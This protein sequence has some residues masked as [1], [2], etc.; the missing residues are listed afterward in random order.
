MT[1]DQTCVQYL[2]DLAQRLLVEAI[3]AK[4]AYDSARS[5]VVDRADFGYASGRAQTYYEVLSTVINLAYSFDL[6]LAILGL[7]GINPDELLL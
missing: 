6:G 5:Q 7:E 4:Q 2:H 3:E 1:M